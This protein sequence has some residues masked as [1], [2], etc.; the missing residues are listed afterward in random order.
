MR[1]LLAKAFWHSVKLVPRNVEQHEASGGGNLETVYK[2]APS[3]QRL[4]TGKQNC[5]LASNLQPCDEQQR[6][7]T[8]CTSARTS[9]KPQHRPY[10][11]VNQ[12]VAD[13]EG[14]VKDL[15]QQLV[16]LFPCHI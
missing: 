11:D 9:Q 1:C 16:A 12:G 8:K 14:R 6:H 13:Q 4:L 3:S 15:G 2:A 7:C 10:D 5:K